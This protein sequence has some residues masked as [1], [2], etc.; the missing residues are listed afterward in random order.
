MNS[1]SYLE[2]EVNKVLG[3]WN[4]IGVPEFLA[5]D[6]YEYYASQIVI[7]GNDFDKLNAYLK[8]IAEDL[9]GY[10]DNNPE[11]RVDLE[12]IAK[13]LAHIF[14]TASTQ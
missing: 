2:S 8:I 5:L 13:Q 3:A 11:H 12:K 1:K 14:E 9:S 4:L 7:I 10:N 6:E